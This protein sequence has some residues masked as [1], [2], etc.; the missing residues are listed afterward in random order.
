[1]TYLYLLRDLKRNTELLILAEFMHNP[2][3]RRRDIAERLGI[4]EQ[5]ISQYIS[6]LEDEGLLTTSQRHPKPTKRGMQLLQERFVRLNEEIESILRRIQIIDT[7]IAIAGEDIRAKSRVGLIMKDG[8]L[9]AITNTDTSSI[10]TARNSAIR[11]EDILI[12]NLS[13][14]VDLELGEILALEIPP[15]TAGGSRSVDFTLARKAIT[16]FAYDEIAV[17]DLIGEVV[18]EKLDLKPTI[19]H[20]PAT[21]CVNALSK[22]LNVIYLGT[23]ESVVDVIRNIDQ[24]RDTTGFAISYRR[25]SVGLKR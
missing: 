16:G 24:L 4:T 25:M 15:E 10:G 7:C 6:E 17:G 3:T 22:G 9:V 13:G 20:S 11:G 8:R 18:A 5:A 14:V 1:M 23:R 2:S 19:V 21:S 12:G